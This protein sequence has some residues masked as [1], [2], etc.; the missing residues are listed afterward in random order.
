MIEY[1]N[2]PLS[3]ATLRQLLGLLGCEPAAMLHPGSFGKLGLALEDYNS[4]DAL[5]GLLC[6]HP[7]VMN[8]PICVRGARAVIARPAEKVREILD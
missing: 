7:E 2:K 8:R 3:E 6:E 1:I 5:V 4:P